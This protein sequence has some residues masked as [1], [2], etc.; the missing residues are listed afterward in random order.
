MTEFAQDN[1]MKDE[2]EA[3]VPQKPR[4]LQSLE[5]FSLRLHSVLG[6]FSG[7]FCCLLTL[8][9]LVDVIG[10]YAFKHPLMGGTELAQSSLV[11][12]V[13]LGI[14]YTQTLHRHIKVTF[15]L[16][17]ISPKWEKRSEILNL[18]VGAILIGLLAWQA[19]IN[20]MQS[21]Q[22]WETGQELLDLPIFPI[23]FAV[24]LGFFLFCVQCIIEII[25]N[26]A[27]GDTK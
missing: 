11:L 1:S 6:T 20:G 3:K 25:V 17:R 4:R 26:L 16:E 18:A 23:K 10:R 5:R 15:I 2:A 13:F 19:F 24:F 21:L 22:T 12:F 9:V 7:F 14:T 8:I 27:N